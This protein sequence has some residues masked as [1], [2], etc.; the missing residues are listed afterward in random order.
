M[1]ERAWDALLAPVEAFL[2]YARVEAGLTPHT[3]AAYHR[4][5]TDFARFVRSRGIPSL[6]AVQRA[7]VTLYLFALR[8]QGLAA[9]T[10]A[11]RLSAL[12]SFYRFLVREGQATS[13]P[14]E[15]V[16][17]PRLGRQLPRVLSV[18][19]VA[20]LLAQ[21]PLDRPEGLRDRAILELLYASGLRVAELIALDVEDVDLGAELVRVVGKGR[22][23]RV[24]PIGS[25]AVR[26][27]RDYLEGARARLTRRRGS[28]ALFVSRSG[29]RLSRQWIW[30]ILRLY[31][32][33]AGI[34]VPVSPHV[35]RHSFATHLLEGG[36]DLRAVQELL[37]H[38]NIATTQIYTHLTRDRIREVFDRAHPRDR[39]P[40]P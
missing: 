17:G 6:L 23:E 29:R 15:D 4:D 10:L 36:A 11:R 27:L 16:R 22:K 37:G 5:L 18:E 40:V 3:C 21:P 14:T 19:E 26:A 31:A 1:D 9:S 8:Q 20:R 24:V 12:R 32:A 13:D 39:M 34:R 2:E 28:S 35:L 7:D 38:A 33:K 30:A 25:Y